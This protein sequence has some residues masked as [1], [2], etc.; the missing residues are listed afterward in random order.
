MTSN[1]EEDDVEGNDL[2]GAGPSS[3]WWE[4]TVE[5][6]FARSPS[7]RLRNPKEPD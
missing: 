6:L 2:V 4:K 5:F 3:F 1:I 7:Y